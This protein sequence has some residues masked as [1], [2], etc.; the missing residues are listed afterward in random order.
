MNPNLQVEGPDGN[1]YPISS[2][3]ASNWPLVIRGLAG[4]LGG[5]IEPWQIVVGQQYAGS[6]KN[7]IQLEAGG[8]VGQEINSDEVAIV[9]NPLNTTTRDIG[10]VD[11][12]GNPN[13]W[14][15]YVGL[16]GN[17]GNI[18]PFN[19]SINVS[20]AI[21]RVVWE[22]KYKVRDGGNLNAAEQTVFI[23]QS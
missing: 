20:Q 19:V 4:D 16:F 6:N 18:D 13:L 12:D 8:Q 1:Y 11:P 3:D 15:Q 21:K 17:S 5:P 10:S 23:Q 22:V 7:F 2:A 14:Q 9:I